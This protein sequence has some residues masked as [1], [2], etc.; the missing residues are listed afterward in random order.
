MARRFAQIDSQKIYLFLGQRKG[1]EH[2]RGE[3]SETTLLER[4]WV[5]R[6]FSGHFLEG[7]R[8]SKNLLKT[9]ENLLRKKLL[10]HPLS[11]T[12]FSILRFS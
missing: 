5:L 2:G 11:L 9:E 4:N 6:R 12:P 1:G 10:S 7:F 8:P 3:G